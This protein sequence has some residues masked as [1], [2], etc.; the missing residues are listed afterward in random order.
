ML[1]KEEGIQ[2]GVVFQI[3]EKEQLAEVL[4]ALL[5]SIR[6]GSETDQKRLAA[7]LLKIRKEGHIEELVRFLEKEYGA[8]ER[9]YEELLKYLTEVSNDRLFV[10]EQVHRT[11]LHEIEKSENLF[12]ILQLKQQYNNMAFRLNKRKSIAEEWEMNCFLSGEMKKFL[13]RTFEKI[14]LKERNKDY[15]IIAVTQLLGQNHAPTRLV[16][17]LCRIIE[18]YLNKKVLLLNVVLKTD[19]QILMEK[20]L[21]L[22]WI[23]DFKYI[24]EAFG[25]F[26]YCY[27]DYVCHGYQIEIKRDNRYEMQMLADTINR[28][29]PYFIWNF[30]GDLTYI[31]AMK[32]FTT[33][34]Y[35]GLNQG[36][37]GVPADIAVNYFPKSP[38]ENK[39]ERQFLQERDVVVKDIVINF[40]YIRSTGKI[41]RSDYNIPKDAFCLAVVGNRLPDDCSEAFLCTMRQVLEQEPDCYLVFIGEEGEPFQA[42]VKERVGFPEQLRFLG[43]QKELC[44]VLRIMDLFVNPVRLGGGTGGI[45]A[46]NEGKPVIALKSG[47]VASF[48]GERFVCESLDRYK[49]LILRYKYDKEFYQ[50]QSEAAQR[51]AEEKV[52]T[53]RD[54]ANMIRDLIKTVEMAD[55][56]D[57]KGQD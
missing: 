46:M 21:K 20:G 14:P 44:E 25:N 35:T 28:L 12:S 39:E 43:F 5:I 1:H 49:E 26:T 2:K 37:Q 41:E 34:L 27:R 42:Y 48:V 52:T 15:I 29:K 47:D 3:M 19:N 22:D 38:V 11:L 17:E 54:L 50:S 57:R 36:Y 4:N 32:E 7:E 55:N 23:L 53:D 16:L 8:D 31:N 10:F 13:G 24:E 56:A 51:R 33:I 30:G 40:S 18:V 9:L 6:S 45:L